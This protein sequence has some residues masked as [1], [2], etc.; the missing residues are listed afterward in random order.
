M[1]EGG[2]DGGGGLARAEPGVDLELAIAGLVLDELEIKVQMLEVAAEL[3]SWALHLNDLRLHF[4]LHTF[5]YVHCL[6][7]QYGLH[8]SPLSAT[9]PHNNGG[10]GEEIERRRDEAKSSFSFLF[11][12]SQTLTH[13]LGKRTIPIGPR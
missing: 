5:R 8:L 9:T 2:T 3:A 13:S 4:D 1:A 11:S 7:R 12:I 6:R 10:P